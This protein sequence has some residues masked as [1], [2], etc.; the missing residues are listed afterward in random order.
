MAGQ[1]YETVRPIVVFYAAEILD[2][3]MLM[4]N[5]CIHT[6]T[7]THRAQLMDDFLFEG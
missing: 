7:S 3:F 4:D 5:N 6:H 2:D 1:R